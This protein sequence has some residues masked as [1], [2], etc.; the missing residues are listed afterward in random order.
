MFDEKA[1]RKVAKDIVA[2]RR[3]LQKFRSLFKTDGGHLTPAAK[4]VIE[5]GIRAGMK[6]SEIASLLDVTPAAI[7]YHT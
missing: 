3:T 2:M 4:A 5:E 7:S 1:F 6:K